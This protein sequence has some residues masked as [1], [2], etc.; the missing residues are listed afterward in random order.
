M[1]E[2]IKH[3]FAHI[4]KQKENPGTLEGGFTLNQIMHLQIK[5]IRRSSYTKLSKW[6]AKTKAVINPK[7]AM[8]SV[9]NEQL[10]QHYIAKA[11]SI[12]PK[13]LACYSMMKTDTTG[14]GLS[15]H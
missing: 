3:M 14:K 7:I 15:F 4:N 6:I 11:L 9:L 13:E 8:N 12:I 1:E 10:L 2:L 5:L